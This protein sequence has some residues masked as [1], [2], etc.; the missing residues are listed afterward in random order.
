MAQTFFEYCNAF[1]GLFLII[2]FYYRA[3]YTKKLYRHWLLYGFLINAYNTLWL[4]TVYPLAWMDGSFIT[5]YSAIAVLHGISAFV[6]GAGCIIIAFAFTK[7]KRGWGRVIAFASL[8]TLAEIIHTLLLSILFA[9]AEG[10]GGY[11]LS[12]G[13]LIGNALSITPLVEYAYYGGGYMLTFILGLLVATIV[14]RKYMRFWY[15]IYIAIFL[16]LLVLHYVVPVHAPVKDITVAAITTDF[17]RVLTVENAKEEFV[18]R[19]EKLHEMT[20]SVASSSPDIIAYPEDARYL[21]YM[22][23]QRYQA[24]QKYLPKTLFVDGDT[25]Q[26]E[27]GYINYSVFYDVSLDKTFFVRGKVFLAPFNEYIPAILI[28]LT[29]LVIGESGLQDFYKEHTYIKDSIMSVYT[30][31][32]YKVGTLICSEIFSYETILRLKR[33]QPDIIIYQTYLSNYHGSP[34]YASVLR[35]LGRVASATLRAP[36]IHVS[37]ASE[38]HIFSPY[39]ELLYTVETGFSASLFTVH[40][41][42]DIT[43]IQNNNF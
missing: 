6:S 8:L 26:R 33:Q 37:N 10:A 12:T 22:D 21:H 13:T 7:V 1:V 20:L 23:Q 11:D 43:S 36:M 38:G 17:Q 18:Y 5:Q 39:G 15:A 25:G 19:T 28:P 40:K 27:N 16:F 31:G 29:R 34:L 32:M 41:D 42:G 3:G 30:Y 24:L 14:E 2:F 35:S 9:G 4:Y